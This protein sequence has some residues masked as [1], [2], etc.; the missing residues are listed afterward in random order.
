[1]P[2]SGKPGKIDRRGF[3]QAIALGA[4]SAA[5]AAG[6]CEAS[7]AALGAELQST[8][9]PL[10]PLS[11]GEL[12]SVS[13]LLQSAS[14]TDQSSLFSTIALTPPN[15]DQPTRRL[16]LAVVYQP[17]NDSTHEH[18]VDL[19]SGSVVQSRAVQGCRASGV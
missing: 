8:P 6:P 16:A 5:A 13:R 17:D 9:H 19:K 3:L 12:E 15:P 7:E 14:K 18:L 1:M 4:A 2:I 10:D 11:S